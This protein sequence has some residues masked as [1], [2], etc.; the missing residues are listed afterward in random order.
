MPARVMASP[1]PMPRPK[2]RRVF[3]FVEVSKGE[4]IAEKVV[5]APLEDISVVES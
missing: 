3:V 2:A 5:A 4:E 1:R